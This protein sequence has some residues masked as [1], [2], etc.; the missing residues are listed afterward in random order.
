M[1][2]NHEINIIPHV[3][4][5]PDMILEC[6]VFVVERFSVESLKETV[7]S[8]KK[9]RIFHRSNRTTNE[10]SIPKNFIVPLFLRTKIGKVIDDDT[11]NQVESYDNNDEEEHHIVNNSKEVQRFL[12]EKEKRK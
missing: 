4:N 10:T 7:E 9:I 11:K 6:H 8:S 12:E 2:Q 5:F 3:V 1:N